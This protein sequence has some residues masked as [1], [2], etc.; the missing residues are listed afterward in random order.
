NGR[1]E[2]ATKASGE[3]RAV[4][5]RYGLGAYLFENDHGET[6]SLI[7]KGDYAA[8]K[9]RLDEMERRLVPSRRMD[10]AYFHHLR[11]TY[12]Q[13]VAHFGAA[14]HDADLALTLGKETGLPLLQMPHFHARLAH[15]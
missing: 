12:E 3:A 13:R 10:W 7:T 4:A 8:A 2:E 15:A 1:Y 9:T 14:V 5:E 6:S 11:S